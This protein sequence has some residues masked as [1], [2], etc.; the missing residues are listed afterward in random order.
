MLL[1]ARKPQISIC[2]LVMGLALATR[3]LPFQSRTDNLDRVHVLQ[4][5][6][7]VV[8]VFGVLKAHQQHKANLMLFWL[9]STAVLIFTTWIY[10][11]LE[12]FDTYHLWSNWIWNALLVITFTWSVSAVFSYIFIMMYDQYVE[13]TQGKVPQTDEAEPIKEE[14]SKLNGQVTVLITHPKYSPNA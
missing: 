5:V 7:T 9:L 13:L 3:V 1:N 14:P 4:L 11:I 6:A 12:F 10:G 2:L 8:L